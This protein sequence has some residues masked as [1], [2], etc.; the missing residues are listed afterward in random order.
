[1]DTEGLASASELSCCLLADARV[2]AGDHHYLPGNLHSCSANP[3]SKEL[4]V[5]K[6]NKSIYSPPPQSLT[7]IHKVHSASK[8]DFFQLLSGGL[9]KL[10]FKGQHFPSGQRSLLLI[11]S[12][13]TVMCS[14]AAKGPPD[15]QNKCS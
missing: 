5:G 8:R 9:K 12:A 11:S 14:E 7:E 6:G 3:T 10:I 2:G 15:K 1:M 13:W 4:P